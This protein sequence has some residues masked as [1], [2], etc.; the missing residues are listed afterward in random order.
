MPTTRNE[1]LLSDGVDDRASQ[2]PLGTYSY[3]DLADIGWPSIGGSIILAGGAYPIILSTV[4]ILAMTFSALIGSGLDGGI[5]IGFPLAVILYGGLGGIIGLLWTGVVIAVTLPL[6]HL[7]VRSMKLRNS[8]VWL[9]AFCGG[10]VAFMAVLP[11]ALLIPLMFN[12]RSA[13]AALV[14]LASGPGTATV[15]GQ[16]GGALGGRRAA[17]RIEAKMEVR[18]SLVAI[19][20]RLPTARD[21]DHDESM[22]ADANRSAFR[23]RTV[24]LLWVS[25][26]LS[27]LLTVIRL[28]GIPYQLI[29][30]VLTGWLVY[31]AATLWIGSMLA[32]KLGP[33]RVARWQT[34]ST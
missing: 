32:K 4:G 17:K 25:V 22:M 11:V 1:P 30:P 7:V 24:H 13:L 31:Q 9:G 14:M 8:L 28:S 23:F 12:T 19:G 18:R 33:W 29:L 16:L 27:L 15:V 21:K 10:L 6:V 34:R 3:S 5:L 20:W 2:V 26:W